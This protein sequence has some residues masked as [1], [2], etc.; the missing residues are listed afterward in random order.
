MAAIPEA[1]A[2]REIIIKRR[3]DAPAAL[4]FDMWTKAEHVARWWAPKGMTTTVETLDLRPGGTY[5]FVMHGADGTDYP[6]KGVYHE[7]VPPRHLVYTDDWD[8]DPMP[9]TPSRVTVTFDERGHQ[10][11]VTLRIVFATAE[12]YALARDIGV[13]EGWQSC[14]DVLAE[15]LLSTRTDKTPKET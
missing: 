11:T 5:R 2:D 7:I 15:E 14:F 4:V 6:V 8:G 1:A 10:T 9:S 13:T 12:G 3:F